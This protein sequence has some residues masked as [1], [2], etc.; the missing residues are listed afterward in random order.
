MIRPVVQVFILSRN[1]PELLRQ[2]LRSILKQDYQNLQIILSDNSTNDSVEKL[3]Q[4]EFGSERIEYR[5]RNPPVTVFDHFQICQAEVSADY[6]MFFHDD[7]VLLPTAISYAVDALQSNT[8]LS[9]VGMNAYVID[10]HGKRT[11][12]FNKKIK[13]DIIL[14]SP[15]QI[16]M[17]YLA[18]PMS[19]VPFPG[20]LYR[21]H[22]LKKSQFQYSNGRKHTDVSFLVQVAKHGSILW[23]SEPLME[24]RIHGT[25]DSAQYDILAIF[26]LCRFLNREKTV[27]QQTIDRYKMVSL[28]AWM[29]AQRN[30]QTNQKGWKFKTLQKALYSLVL[31]HPFYF[32]KVFFKR[33]LKLS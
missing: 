7:D 11:L 21:S 23:L 3:I 17:K 1:R 33:V 30:R 14:C 16:A 6:A 13:E 8:A 12:L 29:L 22:A 27:S 9:A 32:S 18:Y 19:I 2:A 28:I 31:K 15:E 4:N 24:Y 20:Y 10:T 26:S 25:N 5:K